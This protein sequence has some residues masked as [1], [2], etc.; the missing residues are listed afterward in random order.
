LTRIGNSFNA[1]FGSACRPSLT[2]IQCKMIQN[3]VRNAEIIIT[4]VAFLKRGG[5]ILSLSAIPAVS[6]IE[7]TALQKHVM[8]RYLRRS[9]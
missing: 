4:Y 1:T 6:Q 8:K 5:K 2:R 9:V 3:A 7:N